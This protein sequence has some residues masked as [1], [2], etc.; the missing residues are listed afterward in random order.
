MGLGYADGE[1]AESACSYVSIWR[2]PTGV[3]HSVGPYTSVA[4]VSIFWRRW[5]RP[6]QHPKV[7]RWSRL[8]DGLGELDSTFPPSTKW[9]QTAERTPTEA[10][11]PGSLHVRREV[12][13]KGVDGHYRVRRAAAR[14]P[15]A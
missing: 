12:L 8:H 10:A 4:I 1:I 14:F 9:V 3:V 13:L 7:T 11:S 5:H 6:V 15:D 2:A